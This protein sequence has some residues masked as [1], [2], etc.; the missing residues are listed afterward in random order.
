M[1]REIYSYIYILDSIE[2]EYIKSREIPILGGKDPCWFYFPSLY[3]PSKN[4][5]ICK[6][7]HKVNVL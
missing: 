2:E 1:V 4:I 6:N 5:L 3:V 7:G